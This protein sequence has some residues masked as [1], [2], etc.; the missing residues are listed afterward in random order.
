MQPLNKIQIR[1]FKLSKTVSSDF[2]L[3]YQHFGQPLNQA[4]I[5]LVNHALT[6][7]SNVAGPLGWW[8]KII[9][10]GKLIDLNR[11]AV[12]AFNVPGNGFQQTEVHLP[13]NYDQISTQIVADLYWKALEQLNIDKLYAVIGGSLG[14]SIAWE[15]A[16]L[17]PNSIENLI[18]IAC[19]LKASD[20]LIGNVLV[21][22][23]ILKY[24]KTPIETAR[25][26]A[27][28]LY[29]TPASFDLKFN[30]ELAPQENVYKVESW[31]NY[32]GEN[33]KNRFSLTSYQL[34][35]HLLK[36]I[37]SQLTEEKLVE[38][39][40][41]SE[42]RIHLIA[43]DSDYMFSKAE[44]WET[45][46]RIR[47]NKYNISYSEIQSIH[48]HDAFLI[49]NEQINTILEKVFHSKNQNLKEKQEQNKY[50][51]NA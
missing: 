6:G 14:G 21:Q 47:K 50:S 38:F 45:Y 16:F 36:T 19:S 17:K 25:K 7:N 48:G 31:L 26:H 24:S 30:R 9:G 35:N 5:V 51:L 1:N 46:Q 22:D 20:W 28:L 44:Q 40:K 29:R 33:L 18:P 39:S 8:N 27:M 42:T 32:H 13:V 49:E 15:M 37:G 41:Q 11:F 23:E 43:V 34:M 4:P 2:E 12:V 10:E 3:S